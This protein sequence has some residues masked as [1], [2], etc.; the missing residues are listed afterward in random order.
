MKCLK[1]KMKWGKEI[2]KGRG[3]IL[4]GKGLSME[5]TFEQKAE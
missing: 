4:D 2:E 3:V 5:V 1:E